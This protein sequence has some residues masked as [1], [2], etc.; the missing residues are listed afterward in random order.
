MKLPDCEDLFGRK[1][2]EKFREIF[3]KYMKNGVENNGDV[4]NPKRGAEA[5]AFSP[6][7]DME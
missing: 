2:C 4:V 6:D 3:A 1:N 7:S 5:E